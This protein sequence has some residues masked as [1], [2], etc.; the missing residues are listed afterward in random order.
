MSI[1]LNLNLRGKPALDP[2]MD[3]AEVAIH[4]CVS[5]VSSNTHVY[6]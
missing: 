3:Q 6:C 5:G 4:E 2:H 1:E